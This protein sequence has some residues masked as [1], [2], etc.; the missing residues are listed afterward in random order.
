M[1]ERELQREDLPPGTFGNLRGQDLVVA[2]T[3][4]RSVLGCMND[5]SF[6]CEVTITALA[7]SHIA[8]WVN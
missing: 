6:L 4:D 7:G 2:K 5:M 8:T 1:I 3:A